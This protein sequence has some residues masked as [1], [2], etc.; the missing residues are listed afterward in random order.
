MTTW[1]APSPTLR[2]ETCPFSMATM[3]WSGW[4]LRSWTTTSQLGPNW[5]AMP[6]A[7]CRSRSSLLLSRGYPSSALSVGETARGLWNFH[8]R[9]GQFY[10]IIAYF[11]E[12]S[13]I[14]PKIFFWFS[15]FLFDFW[16]RYAMIG[17]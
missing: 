16:G 1:D 14:L 4:R 6:E 7:I 13:M 12:K 9:T 11:P 8:S 3:E 10:F 2:P 15:D 17:V 5:A